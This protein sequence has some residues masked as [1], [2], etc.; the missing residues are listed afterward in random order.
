MSETGTSHNQPFIVVQLVAGVVFYLLFYYTIHTVVSPFFLFAS[1]IVLLY[2]VR[3]LPFARVLLIVSSGFFVVWFFQL[4]SNALSPFILSI[5]L[6]YFLNPFVQ[7]LEKRSVPRWISSL[8]LLTV[9][10]SFLVLSL[11]KII[12]IALAQITELIHNSSGISENIRVFITS[13]K[14]FVFL[15]DINV[16]VDELQEKI[17]SAISSSA[18]EYFTSL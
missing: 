10:V 6:A 7:R 3:S 12:P 16:P 1:I 11:G 9:V 13:N 18:G 14:L 2:S 4:I 8:L 5:I 15:R 17:Q